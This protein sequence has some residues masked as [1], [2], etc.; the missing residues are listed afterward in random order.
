[1][2]AHDLADTYALAF[3]NSRAWSVSD[4]QG[5]LDHPYIRVLGDVRSFLILQIIAQEGEVLTLATHP[6]HRR[7]GLARAC[8]AQAIAIGLDRLFLEV[9]AD[10]APARSLYAAHGFTQIGLRRGYYAR[11]T[12]TPVDALIMARS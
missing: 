5:Y 1:M 11:K 10:N 6:A 4:M 3:P 7:K 8:L 2:T 9:A 12:G